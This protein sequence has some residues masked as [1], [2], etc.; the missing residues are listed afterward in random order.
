M[1]NIEHQGI[2]PICRYKFNEHCS[3][4]QVSREENIQCPVVE[5]QCGHLFHKH[6]I[7]SWLAKHSNYPYKDCEKKF[8]PIINE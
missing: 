5:G 4:C 1:S 7:D 2:C 3:K 6:C 8:I